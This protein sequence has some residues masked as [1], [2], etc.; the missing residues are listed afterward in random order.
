MF[1]NLRPEMPMVR[2]NWSIY[3][4]ADLFHPG[5]H[6]GQR[7]ADGAFLR[8]ERQTL[9]RLPASGDIVFTI[10]IYVDPLDAVTARP[11]GPAVAKELMDQ[12]GALDATQLAYKGMTD[13]RDAV[14]TRLAAVAAQ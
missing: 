1:D 2:W 12:L 14:M 4:D 6:G 7:L 3:G 10:R 5:P 11:D 8:L 9:R 13:E